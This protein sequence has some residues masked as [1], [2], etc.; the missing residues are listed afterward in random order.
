MLPPV[1]VSGPVAKLFSVY[2]PTDV[3]TAIS[4]RFG[5]VPVNPITI[6]AGVF[7]SP[8][9]VK[10]AVVVVAGASGMFAGPILDCS[11]ST[12]WFCAITGLCITAPTSSCLFA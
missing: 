4:S 5:L 12:V 7:V 9:I 8:L 11:M 2:V 10:Y 6:L 1:I 3:F